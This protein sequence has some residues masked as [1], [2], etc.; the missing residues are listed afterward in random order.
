[1]S[2]LRKNHK[3]FTLV[4]MIMVIVITGIIGGMVAVFLQA[5]I[6]QYMDVAR[7][8]ELTDIADTAVRRISRDARTAVPNSVRVTG[9]GGTPCFEFLPTKDGGRYRSA[10]PGDV[11][12]FDGVDTSFDLIG[13]AAVAVSDVVVIGS[14]QSSSIAYDD[15][16][17]GRLREVAAV[18]GVSPA[19]TGITLVA[20]FP[21]PAEVE[22]HRF[23]VVDGGPVTYACIAPGGGACAI[24]AGGDGTCQLVR[25][26]GYGVNSAQALPA[27]A[28][29]PIL[30]DKV[31][32]CQIE[33]EIPATPSTAVF[34]R[35]GLLVVRL[36]LTSGGESV[37]LYN[38]THV[39]NPP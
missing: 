30:A 23:A 10:G 34:P 25:Y 16:Q 20:G 26:S 24:S 19:V 15:T 6:Q 11:L 21:S 31:S 3:G 33:Y 38:E 13:T 12:D 4:E 29:P 36:T 37:S 22:A 9:C 28:N 35:F 8:A 32:A 1:M 7:R 5:P 14:T 2:S 39:I 18:S 27:T 17:A